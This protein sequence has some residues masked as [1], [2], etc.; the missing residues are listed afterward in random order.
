MQFV[1]ISRSVFFSL[2]R[3]WVPSPQERWLSD[4]TVDWLKWLQTKNY[5][6]KVSAWRTSLCRFRG[7][8]MKRKT[9]K[10]D[11]KKS[12]YGSERNVYKKSVNGEEFS[13]E[14]FFRFCLVRYVAGV[15]GD[16]NSLMKLF[17]CTNFHL[18]ANWRKF[19]HFCEYKIGLSPCCYTDLL[20]ICALFAAPASMESILKEAKLTTF[21]AF[22]SWKGQKPPCEPWFI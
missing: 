4:S 22:R 18:H 9:S 10:D 17:I 7:G 21:F 11:L 19:S 6:L 8:N 1:Y 3:A 2:F 5:S 12:H 13:D 20:R 16:R 15:G 14:S